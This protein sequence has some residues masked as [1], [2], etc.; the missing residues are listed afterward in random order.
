MSKYRIVSEAGVDMG[1][2]EGDSPE[3]AIRAMN[4][5]AGEADADRNDGLTVTEIQPS[6]CVVIRK[7]QFYVGTI[8]ADSRPRP[9]TDERGEDLVFSSHTEARAWI[10]AEESDRYVLAN[11][12]A[13]RP[14]YW[15]VP[16][17]FSQWIEDIMSD[18][19]L[20]D[21]DGCECRDDD[22][23]PCG[24]CDKCADWIDSQIE[25]K[26]RAAKIEED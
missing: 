3:A 11:G 17:E 7:R 2:W 20:I 26:L 16:S 22:G 21:W 1:I 13:E 9:V 10:A 14:E 19:S 23:H 4:S 5:E 15:V 24:E 18:G 12:E 8:G 6:P 25:A